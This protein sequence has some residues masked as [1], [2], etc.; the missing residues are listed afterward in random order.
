[1]YVFV[2]FIGGLR[3]TKIIECVLRT[4]P[5]YGPEFKN[6]MAMFD[7]RDKPVLEP[8]HT[9]GVLSSFITYGGQKC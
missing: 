1:M 9:K 2:T 6:R 4:G 8:K 3:A 7:Q 5:Q